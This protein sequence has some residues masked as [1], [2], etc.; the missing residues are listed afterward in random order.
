MTMRIRLHPNAAI[1]G[2]DARAWI[3]NDDANQGSRFADA[4]EE[5]FGKIKCRPLGYRRFDGEFR[6]IKVGKFRYS[7][8][9]RIRGDEIQVIAIM[10]QHRRPGYWKDRSESWRQ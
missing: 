1:E 8:V 7:V 9:Y 2:V 5:A 4:L 6:K 10:H 3:D